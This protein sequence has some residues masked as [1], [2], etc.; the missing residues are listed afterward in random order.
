MTY[1]Q[2]SL[3]DAPYQPHSDTSREAAERIE[4][5]TG[6]LRASVLRFLR[7]YGPATDEQVQRAL[8]MGP[9]TQRPRRVELVRAG[10]V[11]DSGQRGETDSGRRAVRWEAV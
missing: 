8:A 7:A 3:T 1:Q 11:R 5:R 2:L 4:P 9:S 6:T 10:L